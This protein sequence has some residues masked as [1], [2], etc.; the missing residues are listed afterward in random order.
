MHGFKRQGL[1]TR[2]TQNIQIRITMILTTRMSTAV[3]T[4]I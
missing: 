2:T 3:E 1:S 4:M